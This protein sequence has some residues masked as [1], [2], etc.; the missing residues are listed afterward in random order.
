[1]SRRRY[2]EESK[3]AAVSFPRRGPWHLLVGRTLLLCF[4]GSV[5]LVACGPDDRPLEERLQERL[6]AR[7]RRCQARH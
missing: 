4:L 2:T 3:I 5:G 6:D 7:V 1:M